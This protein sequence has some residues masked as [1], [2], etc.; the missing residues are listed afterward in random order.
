MFKRALTVSKTKRYGCEA[1]HAF[2]GHFDTTY[3]CDIWVPPNYSCYFLYKSAN[4]ENVYTSYYNC[5]KLL[6]VFGPL[7][8]SS[9]LSCILDYIYFK[10]KL[11]IYR[12]L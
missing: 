7:P 9:L 1:A 4:I 11:L 3:F 10:L 5:N 12:L 2:G 6:L 8:Q